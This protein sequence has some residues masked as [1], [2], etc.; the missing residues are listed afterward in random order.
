MAVEHPLLQ[1]PMPALGLDAEGHVLACNFAWMELTK[2]SAVYW[3]RKNWHQIQVA[4]SH[5]CWLDVSVKLAQSLVFYVQLPQQKSLT[6]LLSLYPVAEASDLAFVAY[7][8]DMGN[9]VHHYEQSAFKAY[10]QGKGAAQE[11]FNHRMGNAFTS[12]SNQTDT[13][14][15]QIKV[16]RSMAKGLVSSAELLETPL[17]EKQA[18]KLRFVLSRASQILLKA[19]SDG[20]VEPLRS[21]RHQVAQVQS[22]VR[23]KPWAD[24]PNPAIP[25]FEL[26]VLLQDCVAYFAHHQVPITI[27][28]EPGLRV[29][30]VSRNLFM[31]VLMNL[32]QNSIEAMLEVNNSTNK[33]HQI[34]IQGGI[35]DQ[36]ASGAICVCVA[37]SGPG[38][39]KPDMHLLTQAGYSTKADHAGNGL[40]WLANFILSIGGQID[41]GRDSQLGGARFSVYLP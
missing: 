41:C 35:C 25:D 15:R 34:R 17:A 38:I 39:E 1:G 20:L 4:Q 8:Q 24:K 7:A 27:S 33:T 21:I 2:Q 40:H 37:D 26:Q 29:S 19:A 5:S 30:G 10:E 23:V 12:V 28:C 22:E 36:H 6:C 18:V 11:D 13:I 16:M 32:V 31:Q 9:L 14:A 3:Q